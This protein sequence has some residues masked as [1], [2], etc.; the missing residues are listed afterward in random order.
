MIDIR[1]IFD[2]ATPMGGYLTEYPYFEK[3]PCFFEAPVNAA[4]L[5]LFVVDTLDPL[6]TGDDTKAT[7]VIDFDCYM[8]GGRL[9]SD[10]LSEALDCVHDA[11]HPCNFGYYDELGDE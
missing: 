6:E 7:K 8:S 9:E 4:D 10:G 11:D 5:D 3:Y 2:A 1:S